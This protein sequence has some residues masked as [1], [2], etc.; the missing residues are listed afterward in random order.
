MK[1]VTIFYNETFKNLCQ[2]SGNEMNYINE[3]ILKGLYDW[4]IIQDGP[5]DCG[6][7]INELCTA[8]NVPTIMIAPKVLRYFTN[9]IFGLF[10]ELKIISNKEDCPYCGCETETLT[11]GGFGNIW[12]D[13]KCTNK[14]CDYAKTGDTNEN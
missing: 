12:E 14:E 2:L 4:G 9:E 5:E 11:E 13:V 10:Q 6:L 8:Q 1:N 7:T 3:L